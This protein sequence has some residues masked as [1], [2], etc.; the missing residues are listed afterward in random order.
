L[1]A[2]RG[3]TVP[4]QAIHEALE[5]W[6]EAERLLAALPPLSPD[7]ETVRLV[8]AELLITY[9]ELTAMGGATEATLDSSRRVIAESR[10]TMHRVQEKSLRK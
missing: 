9:H 3:E 2:L 8:V 10:A 7:H 6:R 1:V 5:T 4:A